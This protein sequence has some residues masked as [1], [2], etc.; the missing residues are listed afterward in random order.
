MGRGDRKTPQKDASGTV[1][2]SNG[3]R[4]AV[5]VKSALRGQ[6]YSEKMQNVLTNRIEVSM[7]SFN[8]Y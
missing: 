6:M 8:K 3:V 2:R 1:K 5:T 4:S 7:I